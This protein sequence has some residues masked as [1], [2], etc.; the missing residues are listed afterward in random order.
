MV[1]INNQCLHCIYIGGSHYC[2]FCSSEFDFPRGLSA[3]FLEFGN[4]K[5][6]MYSRLPQY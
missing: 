3:T 1:S 2:R 4:F 5:S 6:P